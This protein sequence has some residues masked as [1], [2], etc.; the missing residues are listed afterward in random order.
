MIPIGRI[1]TTLAFATAAAMSG[2]VPTFEFA[3]RHLS[4]SMGVRISLAEIAAKGHLEMIQFVASRQ[5]VSLTN[6][7]AAIR[8]AIYEG[9]LPTLQYLMTH[10]TFGAI[11]DAVE[12]AARCG[13]LP[14]MAFLLHN[15]YPCPPSVMDQAAIHGKLEIVEWLAHNR[16]EGCTKAVR[17]TN[18]ETDSSP[19]TMCMI[20]CWCIYMRRPSHPRTLRFDSSCSNSILTWAFRLTKSPCQ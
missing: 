3:L 20:C 5:M 11:P 19:H 17:T 1:Q 9:Q 2:S 12:S 8:A 7:S 15:G 16:S 10:G 14:V 6:C 13:H 18:R 4:G